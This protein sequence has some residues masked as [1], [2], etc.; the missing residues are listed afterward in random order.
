MSRDQGQSQVYGAVHA[1][2]RCHCPGKSTRTEEDQTHCDNIFLAHS[3]GD[4]PHLILEA[5][6]SVLQE[7]HK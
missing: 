5:D 2:C 3:L 6:A 4:Q 1:S 7:R